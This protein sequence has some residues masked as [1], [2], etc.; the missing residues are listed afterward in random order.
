MAGPPKRRTSR[1]AW[2][3]VGGNGW[4]Q[5]AQTRRSYPYSADVNANANADANVDVNGVDGV[6]CRSVL[7]NRPTNRHTH[8]TSTHPIDYHRF[9]SFW[10]LVRSSPND[11][12][13]LSII[14]QLTFCTYHYVSFL[15]HENKFCIVLI[16]SYANV[17]I[18]ITTESQ[19]EI[20]LLSKKMCR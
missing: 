8:T 16:T 3:H 20:N 12:S 10:Q 17:S 13:F 6:L 15:T 4:G 7:A 5:R 19:Y 14:S 2:T 9:I 18:E 11:R 1:F